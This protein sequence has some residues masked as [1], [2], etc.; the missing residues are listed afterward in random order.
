M[1]HKILLPNRCR[2]GLQGLKSPVFTGFFRPLELFP[3]DRGGRFGRN[4]KDE[5]VD[6]L[7]LVDDEH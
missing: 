7:D 4:I 6:A 2:E 5:A 1:N 3:L